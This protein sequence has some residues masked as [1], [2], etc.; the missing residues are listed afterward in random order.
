MSD[1]DAESH[2]QTSHS[3]GDAAGG[4][5]SEQRAEDV[6]E[7][8]VSNSSR[9]LARVAGRVREEVEDIVAEGRELHE[10]SRTGPD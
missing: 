4:R 3:D 8:V 7:R 5:S 2:A 10:R 1:P 9:W 6:V